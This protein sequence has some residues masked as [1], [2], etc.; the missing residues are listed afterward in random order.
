M[1]LK[2]IAIAAVAAAFF[3]GQAI[4]KPPADRIGVLVT[5]WGTPEGFSKSYYYGIG[6]RSR[7]GEA[8]TDP[9][10]PCADEFV[11]Q[12]PFRSQFG[13][14]PHAVAY[15][16]PGAERAHD[17][18]G[19]WRKTTDGLVSVID[20]AIR[21]DP[22]A[23]PHVALIQMKD[24][25]LDLRARTIFSPNKWDPQDYL[26]D[27]V[28]ATAPNGIPDVLELD[29][30]YWQRVAGILRPGVTAD[31]NPMTKDMERYLGAWFNRAYGAR[32]DLRF[33]N[34]EA[35]E[36]ASRRHDD[37]AVEMAKDGISRLLLTRETTDN[38]NY[39]NTFAT[40]SW[41]VR[42][43]CK[44]GFEGKIALD[45]IRQVGRTPEYNAM[46]VKNIRRHL[47]EFPRKS[48]VALLYATYGLPWPGGNPV[49]GPFSAPQPWIQEVYHENAYNNFLSFKR[50][51]EAAFAGDWSV[52][53]AKSGGSG[54][55]DA[56]TRNLYGYGIFPASFYGD[57]DDPL[58]FTT[59]RDN[60]EQAIR[61]D[62]RKSI[63]IVVSHWYYNGLDNALTIREVN[64]L[65]LNT[66]DEMN[67]GEFAVRWCERYSGPGRYEQI[68]DE[69][70]D[71]RWKGCP[72]GWS[73][74][75]LSE[76]FDDFRDDFFEGYAQRIRGGVER[77]GELP[78]F[79]VEVAAKARISKLTGGSVAAPNGA[80]LVVRPD[81]HPG[82]PEGYSWAK[83]R[84]NPA[85]PRDLGYDAQDAIR[86]FNEFA[87]ADDHLVSAWDDFT[88]YVGAQARDAR[89]R[90]IAKPKGA[91]S[92]IVL[93][94]P[95]RELFNAP[96]T[97]TLP[98]DRS[99]AN[100][101]SLSPMIWNDVTGAFE[102][103]LAVPG[104]DSPR[105]DAKART[106][107][108]DVQV[109]GLFVL[110]RAG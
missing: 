33:G 108:F 80:K 50:T 9:R 83:A 14:Y 106:I 29:G 22:A 59:I 90:P 78:A 37:V 92:P 76:A 47:E 41:I 26:A 60:L 20:P 103:V 64:D 42:A 24:V 3:A 43:L 36:N 51:A 72:N 99:V 71:G 28:Q 81:A 74:I 12:F 23:A 48:E 49:A 69:R 95:Y 56:R 107:T 85:P 94:G 58:R 21:F 70:V 19:V 17:A 13:V 101:A 57:A 38:N 54:G 66:A 98:Y 18:I 55:G 86:P 44:A 10:D 104:G 67:A 84:R 89:G 35:I 6:Y 102:P 93:F 39:A 32:I 68:K 61:V 30:P 52:T 7:I 45:Q 73:R 11:G 2:Q 46:V 77:F 79:G 62:G 1:P 25:P 27:V 109:L 105:I 40:R 88:A 16:T 65:P 110:A 5:D 8:Q 91:A 34:Y 75:V 82:A 63:V 15:K 4:A 87:H 53:F 100:P 96:A 31:L 97:I